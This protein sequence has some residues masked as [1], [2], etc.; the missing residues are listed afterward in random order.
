MGELIL[1]EFKHFVLIYLLRIWGIG[2][3]HAG[4]QMVSLE[5][6]EAGTKDQLSYWLRLLPTVCRIVVMDCHVLLKK[7]KEPDMCTFQPIAHPD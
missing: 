6:G 2:E 7:C 1:V 4:K 3:E 5:V